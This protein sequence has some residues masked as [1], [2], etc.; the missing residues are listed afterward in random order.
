M[1]TL[2][3]VRPLSAL[4]YPG[5]VCTVVVS[6]DPES[7]WPVVLLG[8]RDEA[9]DRP[10]D[11]PGAWWPDRGAD[12]RGVRDREAGG[13]WL[14]TNR[15]P[16]RAAV[17]L[18][19]HEQVPEPEGG[20]VSRGILPLD[21]VTGVTLDRHPRTRTF[22]LVEADTRGVRYTTWNGETVQTT[23]LPPG[24]HM[25]THEGPDVASVPRET[26]WL[27]EFAAAERPSGSL[28]SG[29]WA[30]WL[31]ILDRSSSLSTDDDRALFRS[32]E[33]D[34]HRSASLSVTVLALG[35]DGIDFRL[36]RLEQPGH[37][38]APLDWQ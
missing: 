10:W 38:D 17:V 12:V 31:A 37:L 7:P 21:A 33:F 1:R 4:L 3:A 18:N 32:D 30:P 34:G 16:S 20:F 8:L 11:P 14:A 9:V 28:G 25:I 24:V 27:P 35:A 13:A 23:E 29:T 26:R 22:N 2:S 36:A 15:A 19:R 5:R 6:F